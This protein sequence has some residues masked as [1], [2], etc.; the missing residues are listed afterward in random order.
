M[1]IISAQFEGLWEWHIG[2]KEL[3]GC[4][5]TMMDGKRVRCVKWRDMCQDESSGLCLMVERRHFRV[6]SRGKTMI[7][8]FK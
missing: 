5:V 8:G 2:M 1:Y 3:I 7:W 4:Y 6:S